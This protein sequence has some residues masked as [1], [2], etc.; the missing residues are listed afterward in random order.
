[1]AEQYRI[2][3]LCSA[4]LP[5]YRWTFGLDSAFPLGH[6]A[7]SWCLLHEG[8]YDDARSKALDALRYGGDYRLLREIITV[9]DSARAAKR[10]AWCRRWRT[11]RRKLPDSLQ[12]DKKWA[13]VVR[14]IG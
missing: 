2:T 8:Q 11:E 6:T 13:E 4:A 7:Y 14:A 1:M 3:G 9:A 10:A 12:K 5:L